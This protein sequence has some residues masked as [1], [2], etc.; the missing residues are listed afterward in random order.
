VTVYEP[1]ESV[2]PAISVRALID[3]PGLGLN[4]HSSR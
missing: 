1:A 2:T 4:V 3:D